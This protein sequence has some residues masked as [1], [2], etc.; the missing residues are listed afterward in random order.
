M[1]T[2]KKTDDTKH[3]GGRPTKYNPEFHPLLAESLAR[4]GLTND[5]ISEKLDINPSTLAAW[6]NEHSEFSKAIKAGK[7]EP[8]SK[9]E[10]SLFELATGYSHDVEKPMVVG[11]G[12]GI[13]HI[14]I[15]KYRERMAPH[16]TAIIFWLKNRK[17]KKWRD[18][19]E[20]ELSGTIG[21]QI[22]DDVK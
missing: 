2:E 12:E 11:D 13:S 5:Q 6:M 7:E 8:D 21:V 10:R 14:E 15:A 16:P 18:K 22:V 19:Q 17:P 9:V 3:P 20:T 1:K 4:N